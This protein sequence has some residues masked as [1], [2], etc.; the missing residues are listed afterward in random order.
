[1][2]KLSATQKKVVFSDDVLQDPYPTYARMHE[3]GPLHYVDVGGKVGCLGDFQPCR[4]FRHR[5]GSQAFRQARETDA[6]V[7]A[8]QS[9][10]GI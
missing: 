6:I 1:M 2:P 8:P 3:E 4:M 10:G 5:E 9:A 7:S